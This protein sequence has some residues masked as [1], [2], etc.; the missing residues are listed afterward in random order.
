MAILAGAIA[1]DQ[2]TPQIA[3]TPVRIALCLVLAAIGALLA[4]EAYRRWSLQERAMR[5]QQELP[6]R[7]AAR[8]DDRRRLRRRRRRRRPHP[9][10]AV[11]PPPED[12]AARDPGLQPERS[13]LGLGIAAAVAAA[14]TVVLSG[15]ILY[16]GA[17]PA[18]RS[19][20]AHRPSAHYDN[21][22]R[23]H[24]RCHH[25][26]HRAGEVTSVGADSAT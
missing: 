13:S 15:C 24:G 8:G 23:R 7:L 12:P 14:A 17:G 2:L 5:N 9:P 4:V 1:V 25:R 3:P 20:T 16:R 22:H 11:T 10:R 18:H 21:G 6:P 19:R 26:R